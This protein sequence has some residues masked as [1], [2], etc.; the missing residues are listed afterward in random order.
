MHM[1]ELRLQE[2]VV[3]NFRSIA[4]RCIIPLDGSITLI[5]GANGAGK[6]SL[7]SAIEL[8]ATG[9]VGFLDEQLGDA[10]SLLR[11]HDFP[12]GQ[13]RLSVADKDDGIRIGSF[14]LNGDEVSG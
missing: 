11:N 2:L 3:E 13:V 7:L 10:R 5:H 4:G 6:T 8:G 9:S 12:L 14:E 1:T